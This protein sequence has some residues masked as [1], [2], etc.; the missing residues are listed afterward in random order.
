MPSNTGTL[1]ESLV[2][3]LNASGLPIRAENNTNRLD[4]LNA[5]LPRRLPQSFESFLSRYSFPSFDLA[6]ITLFG[7]E[8]D[9]NLYT[10]EAAAAKGSLSEVLLPRG[11]LQI[12]RP[13]TGSFDAVCFDLNER[14]QNRECPIVQ[15][16]H[17]E[18]LCNCRIKISSKLWPSFVALVE[19]FLSTPTSKAGWRE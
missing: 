2:S 3:N 1:I 11:Y 7:W 18:V 16:D 4:S 9:E 10:Q 8:S 5:K 13:Y 12:G 17:E 19:N 6:G 15:V 14:G